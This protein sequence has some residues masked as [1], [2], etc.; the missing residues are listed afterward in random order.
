MSSYPCI[1]LTLGG[2]SWMFWEDF[3]NAVKTLLKSSCELLEAPGEDCGLFDTKPE[4]LE[5]SF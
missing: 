4:L 2:N 3:E 5:S 1:L